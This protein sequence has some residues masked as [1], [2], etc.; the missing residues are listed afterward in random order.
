MG[1]STAGC[2][3]GVGASRHPWGHCP[4][5]LGEAVPGVCVCEEQEQVVALVGQIW[6]RRGDSAVSRLA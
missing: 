6:V 1:H 3:A 2:R 5:P 4:S